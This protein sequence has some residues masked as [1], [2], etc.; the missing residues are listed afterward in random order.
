MTHAEAVAFLNDLEKRHD[1]QNML[2]GRVRVWPVIR[3]SVG[4]QLLAEHLAPG[5]HV[6]GSK[7]SNSGRLTA[8]TKGLVHGVLGRYRLQQADLLFNTHSVQLTNLG[9]KRVDRFAHPILEAATSLGLRTCIV[10][11]AGGSTTAFPELGRAY[12]FDASPSL[13]AHAM[14]HWLGRAPRAQEVQGLLPLLEEVRVAHPSFRAASLEDRLRNFTFYS[15]F[16]TRILQKVKPRCVFL[17]SWYNIEH[18]ALVHACNALS[19]PVV[20]LQHGVQGA[21]HL[22]Y[23]RWHTVPTEG[24]SMMPRLFWC[25]DRTSTDNINSWSAHTP[26]QALVL[27]DPW[28]ETTSR[29][30]ATVHWKNDGRKRVLFTAQPLTDILPDRLLD[31]IAK[32]LSTVQW[33]IRTHP[34]RPTMAATVSLR[35]QEAD[36]MD[37]V[38]IDEAM[39]TPL[40]ALLKDCDLHVTQ[41]SSTV[42]EAAI[43]GVPSIA[44]HVSANGLYPELIASGTLI[45][46]NTDEALAAAMN[47]DRKPPVRVLDKRT[48]QQRLT[49]VLEAL[50][51]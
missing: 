37:K 17:V 9:G 7:H 27:G 15:R 19:I 4:E 12:R 14:I 26:H 38:V 40:A 42:L 44:I 20:D 36:L 31:T 34:N 16:H 11:H 41:Y 45:V 35:I 13:N 24:W 2:F 21:A 43:M 48:M 49:T 3:L 47:M 8:L 30:A 1:V 23:G 50:S 51:R 46:P 28:L 32:T 18:M 22:A 39:G 6:L 25:W 10:E 29:S 33:I 5:N